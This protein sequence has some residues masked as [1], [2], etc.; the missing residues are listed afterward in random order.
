MPGG[1]TRV[2][3]S[4][5][6]LGKYREWGYQFLFTVPGLKKDVS[7][8]VNQLV[9]NK[10][11]YNWTHILELLARSILNDIHGKPIQW[12]P[13][14]IDPKS[15]ICSEE[16]A[17]LLQQ[18]GVTAPLDPRL[19][20][21]TPEAF[22]NKK[23]KADPFGIVKYDQ[24]SSIPLPTPDDDTDYSPQELQQLGEYS[25][26]RLID[27]MQTNK[28]PAVFLCDWAQNKYPVD[29]LIHAVTKSWANHIAIL[30]Q[31][32][33]G[34]FYITQSEMENTAQQLQAIKAIF[35]QLPGRLTALAK[36]YNVSD[37][38][39]KKGAFSAI[40]SFVKRI[41][42]A[43]LDKSEWL[44]C[45]RQ[46]LS[47][48]Q[49]QAEAI[50]P[51]Y[52]VID[53]LL[54][55]KDESPNTKATQTESVKFKASVIP[56]VLVKQ[57]TPTSNSCVRKLVMCAAVASAGLMTTKFMCDALSLE[58]DGSMIFLGAFLI[59][60]LCAVGCYLTCDS[61]SRDASS[62]EVEPDGGVVVKSGIK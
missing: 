31:N 54:D 47:Q 45:A 60:A 19:K 62:Q 57:P 1:I 25:Y 34:E 12:K 11:A 36:E 14:E 40:E 16:A 58:Q 28:L 13:L 43:G 24:S 53:M 41:E 27:Y 39:N 52:V 42:Y 35:R 55:S 59:A 30:Y 20:A 10:V 33:Q 3:A 23:N 49:S 50:Y 26:E 5:D 9:K 38:L 46:C 8:T 61:D 21:Y 4:K 17:F 44:A 56:S 51:D 2:P 32:E 37:E 48:R 15:M 22:V 18:A 29:A 6:V 7:A